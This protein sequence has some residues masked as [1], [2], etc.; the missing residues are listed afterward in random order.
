MMMQ[1]LPALFA[2]KKGETV[3]D[4]WMSM[5][6]AAPIFGVDWR[7][8]G[9]VRDAMP[10]AV[11]TPAMASAVVLTEGDIHDEDQEEA[12]EEA[13]AVEAAANDDLTALKGVGPKMAA[14]LNAMGLTSFAQLAEMTEAN[15]AD[16]S[17]KLS[18][19]RDRPARDDWAGQARA[20]MEAPA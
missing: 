3:L 4:Y 9:L 11:A 7:F 18:A 8:A 13:K 10:K 14:E 17:A 20:L 19:F 15:I 12:V 6:P 1:S 5:S 16:L 2:P